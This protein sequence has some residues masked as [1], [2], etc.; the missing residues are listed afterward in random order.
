MMVPKP[1]FEQGEAIDCY[2]DSRPKDTTVRKDSPAI[3]ELGK[4]DE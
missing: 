1:T 3:V 2:L 4:K